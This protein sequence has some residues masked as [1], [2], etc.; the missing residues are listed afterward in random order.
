MASFTAFP[1]S[2]HL[3]RTSSELVGRAADFVKGR[4]HDFKVIVA[5]QGLQRFLYQLTFPYQSI[6]IVGLGATSVELGVVNN[7]GL[8]IGAVASPFTG[9]L[10]DR[11]GAKGVYL[12]GL[13]LLALSPLV[14]AVASS[15]TIVI[16]G[17]VLYWLGMRVS[18]TAC[19]VIGTSLLTNKDR[20]TS[21]N[22]CSMFGSS[23]VMVSPMLGAILVTWF[24]GVNVDGIRPLFY[25]SFVG[26][27]LLLGFA[28]WRLSNA[29][30][31]LPEVTNLFSGISE[32]FARGRYLKRW[33]VI[34]AIN[35]L[36]Q[37]MILPFTQLFA[38]E[39][40]GAQ[41]YVLGGMV[42]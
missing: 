27:V 5:R 15:W 33:L 7:V 4:P 35:W 26:G 22:L 32:V 2:R 10:I 12:I 29:H 20:A 31:A 39:V 38:H 6:F 14:Y 16:G 40:K 34:S 42:T 24:G 21:M 8:A 11:H 23:M 13:A 25:I 3:R 19:S 9:W 37:S 1:F 17:M 41:Q 18:G 30:A 36:P 28:A